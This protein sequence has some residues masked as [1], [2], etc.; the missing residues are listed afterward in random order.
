MSR[1]LILHADDLGLCL[2]VNE[3]IRDSYENGFLTSTS[4]RVNGPAFQHAIK[5]VLPE[6][7]DLGVGLH[8]N[9]V[10]GKTLRVLKQPSS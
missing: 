4:L 6:C 10:E 8:L 2:A 3:G 7:P 9:L 1:H 5:N